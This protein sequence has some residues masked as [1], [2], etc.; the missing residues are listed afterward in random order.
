VATL[1]IRN[2]EDD[3]VDA[4][5]ARAKR[6]GR[7]LEAEIRELLRGAATGDSPQ[8]LRD[9]ADW[10][11]ALTPNVPQTDSTEMV[12]ADHGRMTVWPGEAP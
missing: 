5:K 4:L 10:I 6:N 8:S 11:A 7:S 1:T 3:L 9:L 2:L 12:R